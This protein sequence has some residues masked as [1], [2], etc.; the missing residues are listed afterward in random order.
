MHMRSSPQNDFPHQKDFS[1]LLV[2]SCE[3]TTTPFKQL[4]PT[5]KMRKTVPNRT[6]L[7][8]A[9]QPENDFC[10]L[11]P[12]DNTMELNDT[13]Q[14]LARYKE[15]MEELNMI[16]GRLYVQGIDPQKYFSKS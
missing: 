14:Y 11:P 10:P 5:E 2:I 1:I 7:R 15:L 13:Q 9:E 12:K 6:L 8:G 4:N 3:I 16:R